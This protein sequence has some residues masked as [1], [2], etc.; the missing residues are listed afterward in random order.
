M[1]RN[2][3]FFLVADVAER[4][5]KSTTLVA[6]LADRGEIPMLGRPV[7]GVRIFDPDEIEELANRPACEAV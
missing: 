2:R 5:G 6:N 7:R 1:S 3:K 4:V